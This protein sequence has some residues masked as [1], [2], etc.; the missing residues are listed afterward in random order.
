MPE[1]MGA[2]LAVGWDRASRLF[3]ADIPAGWRGGQAVAG[4]AAISGPGKAVG[5]LLAAP[6]VAAQSGRKADCIFIRKG[7]SDEGHPPPRTNGHRRACL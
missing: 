4:R 1:L 6:G 7:I 2:L 5:H 3:A